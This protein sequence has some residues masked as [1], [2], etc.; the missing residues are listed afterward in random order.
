MAQ[1]Q[2]KAEAQEGRPG[3]LSGMSGVRQTPEG[4]RM[5]S[6]CRHRT[7]QPEDQRGRQTSQRASSLVRQGHHHSLCTHLETYDGMTMIQ[8]KI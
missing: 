2:A 8:V 1:A 7:N 6:M 4:Q 5:P 3:V